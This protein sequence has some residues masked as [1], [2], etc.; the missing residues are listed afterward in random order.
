MNNTTID[1]QDAAV[2]LA[3]TLGVGLLIGIERERRKG[4]GEDRAAAGLRTFTIAALA[5]ALAQLLPMPGLVVLGAGVVALLAALS[6]WKS[7]SRDPGLTTELA[8]FVTYL[9]GV[10][11]VLAPALGAAC[12]A[13]L[14]LLLAARR[15][16][17]RLATD[18]LS[19][20]ELH[21]GL[22]LAALALIVLPLIPPGPIA[23]LGGIDPRPLA[24]M[25]VLI[26][27]IQAAGH[28][29][30]R[31]L[32]ARAGMLGSGFVSGFISSTATVA[33]FGSKARAQPAQ[34]G[35][36]A[37][38]AALSGVA[39][40]AQALLMSAALSP[41]GAAALLPVA[42]AGAAGAAA[43]GLLPLLSRT[44]QG[45][46]APPSGARSALRP[47]EALAVAS[48]LAIVALLVSNAQIR[49]GDAGLQISVALAGLADAHSPIA[50]MASLHAAGKL[51]AEHFVRGALIAVSANTLTRCTVAVM[52][53]GPGYALRVGGA[54]VVSL[55]LAWTTALLLPGAA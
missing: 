55:A 42:L 15:R 47:R 12:G 8:L 37:G 17:H 20:Q 23:L 2:G 3:V 43:V 14:A 49:F 45:S 4:Q 11:T 1:L 30:V 35:V 54:L 26:L 16:L 50:S 29:A 52:A 44:S 48:A 22:L 7:Q 33:S 18:L 5:G 38:G 40:W 34:A 41:A 28:M 53:G 51:T 10:Q 9:I 25:V 32:G 19:E 6:Y 21:D 24:A 27:A 36:L 31:W 46:M 13:G 39:T